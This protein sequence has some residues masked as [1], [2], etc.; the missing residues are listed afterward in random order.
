ML[1]EVALGYSE[2][3]EHQDRAIHPLVLL[4]VASRRQDHEPAVGQ[5]ELLPFIVWT[6]YS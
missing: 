1:R 4:T 6:L 3:A 5:S 2:V